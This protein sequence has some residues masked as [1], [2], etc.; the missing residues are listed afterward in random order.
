VTS[1]SAPVGRDP[2][3]QEL[4]R[5]TRISEDEYKREDLTDVRFVPLVGE[6]GW[7]AKEEQRRAIRKTREPDLA[8]QIAAACE[9]FAAIETAPLEQLLARVGDARIVLIGE[10]THGTSE[11]YRMRARSVLLQSKATGRMPHGSTTTFGTWSTHH[12]SGVR[13]RVS[14]PGCGATTKY[15]SL[16]VGCARITRRCGRATEPLSTDLTSIAYTIQFV[17]Y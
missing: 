8:H 2:R 9:P 17:Q 3:L 16:W 11:F 15:V 14:Q 6:E 5:I 7:E 12:P 13:L 10:A 1:K 4:V